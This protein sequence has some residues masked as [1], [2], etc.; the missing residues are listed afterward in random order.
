MPEVSDK[1]G[2]INLKKEYEIGNT[3]ITL[4]YE[5][6]TK[7]ETEKK[8]QELMKTVWHFLQQSDNTVERTKKK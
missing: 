5:E 3:K 8:L 7:Q 4:E 2:E 1:E 6:Q